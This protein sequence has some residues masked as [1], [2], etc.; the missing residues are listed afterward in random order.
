MLF[1]ARE[2]Q[3][4]DTAAQF[5]GQGF[6]DGTSV[7]IVGSASHRARIATQLV[8]R[9]FNV[10]L[11]Q[12]RGRYCSVDVD[13]VLQGN[14]EGGRLNVP[15]LR[16]ALGELVARARI[17]ASHTRLYCETG[18]V[19]WAQ[20]KANEAFSVEK[21]LNSLGAAGSVSI[22][23]P[24]PERLFN[25]QTDK[26][27]F[28]NV[29]GAHW[30]IVRIGAEAVSGRE[31]GAVARAALSRVAPL[32]VRSEAARRVRVGRG[33]SMLGCNQLFSADNE[34]GALAAPREFARSTP[35][36]LVP[37][38]GHWSDAEH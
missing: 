7:I 23:S 4:A 34:A 17:D 28:E 27:L 1:F 31:V 26:A 18:A 5:L 38:N 36:P 15:K 8:K 12:K 22:C 13:A 6:V 9:G 35:V 14:F 19:L 11:G 16:K 32:P 24:Y 33:L 20:G 25:A 30:Q 2:G 21:L 37:G 29:V 10:V 3:L